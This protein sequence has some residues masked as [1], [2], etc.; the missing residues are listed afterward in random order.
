MR[1]GGKIIQA[2]EV[3]PN[4]VWVNTI[5]AEDAEPCAIYCD[6]A[7]HKLKLGDRLW[8]QAGTA[9]WTSQHGG[10]TVQLKKLGFSGVGHPLG[11]EYQVRYN[12]KKLLD[13]TKFW[14]GCFVQA[15][16]NV[17]RTRPTREDGTFCESSEPDIWQADQL[18]KI[19]RGYKKTKR[20]FRE[21]AERAET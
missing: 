17:I 11:P 2:H 16:E 14:L 21:E 12:Y 7:G 15:V 8:R 4:R 20:R 9:H 18:I 5:D 3:A 19:Y 6:P 10:A 13:Q 1:V